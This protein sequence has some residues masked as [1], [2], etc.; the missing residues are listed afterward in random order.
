[1]GAWLQMTAAISPGSSGSPVLDASGRVVGVATLLLRDS[2]GL[3]F[4]VPSERI[5]SALSAISRQGDVHPFS[6]ASDEMSS[7]PDVQ[8]FGQMFAP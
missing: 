2:Q 5:K 8:R 7:D 1:M 3:N 6:E 4:A